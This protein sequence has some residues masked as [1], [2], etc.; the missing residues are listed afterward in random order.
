MRLLQNEIAQRRERGKKLTFLT[1][2]DLGTALLENNRKKG[3][4]F[5]ELQYNLAWW[6]GNYDNVSELQ[7]SPNNNVTSFVLMYINT[8]V[9]RYTCIGLDCNKRYNK[10]GVSLWNFTWFA[11]LF[12]IIWIFI[13]YFS[14]LDCLFYIFSFFL[15][16]PFDE[17][18]IF[19]LFDFT[20]L[21][22]KY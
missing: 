17:R 19:D 20:R 6:L 13:V 16:A 22:Q 15:R 9:S 2:E 8:Y 3:S 14:V 5:F 21:C 4:L 1:G 11:H 12:H 7:P 10:V 18:M